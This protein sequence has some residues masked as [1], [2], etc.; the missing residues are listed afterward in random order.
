MTIKS[1]SNKHKQ[2]GFFSL[3]GIVVVIVIIGF[4]FVTAT[5]YYRK[6][7]AEKTVNQVTSDAIDAA[8]QTDLNA[9]SLQLKLYLAQNNAYPEANDCTETPAADTICLKTTNVNEYTYSV[10]NT[11]DPKTFSLIAKNSNGASY[12]VTDSKS[13]FKI[14]NAE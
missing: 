7:G 6:S 13:P 8:L 11:T 4:L 3:V 1:F 5:N 10:D 14:T 9:A 2:A 12:K